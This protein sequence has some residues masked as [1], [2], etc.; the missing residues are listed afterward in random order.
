[1]LKLLKRSREADTDGPV[2]KR[3]RVEG[4]DRLSILS[5][6]LLLRILS[7]LPMSDLLLCER[8]AM[9]TF[10]EIQKLTAQTL[11]TFQTAG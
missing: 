9:L 2:A 1:M 8:S 4:L 11:P 5:D 6:E 3:F 7:Y 10:Y